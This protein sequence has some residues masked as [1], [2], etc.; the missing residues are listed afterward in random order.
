MTH[1]QN[2]KAEALTFVKALNE[3]WTKGDGSA[4]RDYFHPDMVAITAT[5]HDI[6][7]GREACLASW[8]SF[9]GAAK[10]RC[11]KEVEPDVRLHGNTAVVT[12][13]YD[14]AFDMDGETIELG[15]RDM[16]VLVKEAGRWWAIADQFSPFPVRG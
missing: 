13:V 2:L 15:G 1:E 5:D 7:R 11:W 14:M 16:F 8:Q 10:V 3:T 6:L 12:Y 4:L 9:A